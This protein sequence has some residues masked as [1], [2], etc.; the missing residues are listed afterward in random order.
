MLTIESSSHIAKSIIIYVYLGAPKSF[1]SLG[2]GM[3]A[4]IRKQGRTEKSM[5]VDQTTYSFRAAKIIV[6]V[7][8][9]LLD[10]AGQY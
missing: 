5:K 8:T 6:L 3:E 4:Q 7:A 1:K 10:N 9:S 2:G